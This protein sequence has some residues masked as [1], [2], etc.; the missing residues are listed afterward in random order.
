[1]L[2]NMTIGTKLLGSFFVLLGMTFMVAIVALVKMGSVTYMA[3]RADV[4]AWEA[5]QAT[6]NMRNETAAI[7]EALS[8][9]A[10][11]AEERERIRLCLGN[12]GIALGAVSDKAG[13]FPSFQ[14]DLNS[15]LAV[16][17]SDAEQMLALAAVAPG[18]ESKQQWIQ[19]LEQR[20]AALNAGSSQLLRLTQ[21]IMRHYQNRVHD[22][23]AAAAVTTF[24]FLVVSA[25]IGVGL[26]LL[27]G[28]SLTRRIVSLTRV[29][30]RVASGD[31]KIKAEYNERNHD[32][33][34]EFARIFNYMIGD[35][36]NSRQEVAD[37]SRKLEQR[38]EERTSDLQIANRKLTQI[39]RLKTEFLASMSHE[40]RTPLN[41]I[42]GFAEILMDGTSGEIS[43]TQ[44]EYCADIHSSAGHLLRMI[45]D[46]LDLSKIEAG[47][48]ELNIE[49]ISVLD[50]VE[51]VLNTLKGISNK[52]GIQLVMDVTPEIELI[53]ADPVKFKQML[54]N[55]LSNACKFAPEGGTVRIEA[56]IV[57]SDLQVSVIDNGPGIPSDQQEVIFEE[58][59]QVKGPQAHR[60]EGTGLGLALTRKLVQLHG[61]RIWVESRLGAGS[62]FHFRIPLKSA[63][64]AV[65]KK[66]KDEI[67]LIEAA[68]S[69]GPVKT[70]V[71]AGADQSAV[72]IV[73][74]YLSEAGYRVEIT[75][76][77]ETVRREVRNRAPF[78][79]I[80]DT[81]LPGGDGWQL[82]TEIKEKPET[83]QIPV[84]MIV[85]P[86][87]RPAIGKG[88][89]ATECFN[90]PVDRNAVICALANLSLRRTVE[91]TSQQTILVV[92]NDRGFVEQVS[93][94]LRR[95][96]FDVAPALTG[97]DGVQQ[98][99]LRLPEVAVLNVSLMDMRGCDV[100]VGI[101]RHAVAHQ[102]PII[103]YYTAALEND[104]A[105]FLRSK[106]QR[107][108][109]KSELTPDRIAAEVK[110]VL[111]EQAPSLSG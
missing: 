35:I 99:M 68:E 89:G 79:V 110:E 7:R 100:I 55:L 106:T 38:V 53:E 51:G 11:G 70:V 26:A 43:D 57:E 37:Y 80:L 21:D 32:E 6:M 103:A 94:R 5:Y 65:V 28:G 93:S 30:H 77:A 63:E 41:A 9:N 8:R 105:E 22:V 46:I 97:R 98:F 59:H 3:R 20:C 44:K 84:M 62:K 96:G 108:F 13:Q 15:A 101:R 39:D 76:D 102:T 25:G 50:S 95:A 75:P 107:L 16:L 83:A 82:L 4:D 56:A 18:D 90:K 31:Y 34:T 66:P 72:H 48:M 81:D 104:E 69:I 47:K 67:E 49:D 58:F 1:M 86:G 87:D 60:R 52:K 33:L 42:M 10:V 23:V 27:Q 78:A 17:K 85:G 91:D 24:I 92:D 54:Y 12:I 19:E 109:D 88:M 45:S 61:G 71:I 74:M 73:G 64:K 29:S 14:K 40:L 111:R 36:E 2:N